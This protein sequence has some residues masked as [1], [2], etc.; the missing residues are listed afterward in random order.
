M[1]FGE[2]KFGYIYIERG[3]RKSQGKAITMNG[4]NIKEL[5]E[6]ESYKYLGQDESIGYKG[7]LNKERVERE[8]YRRVREIWSSE[9]NARNK[10]IAHNSFAIPVLIP[11]IGILD[12][13]IAEIENIDKKTRKIL[14]MMG[15]FHRNSGKD[16]LYLKRIDGGRGLKCFEESYIVRIVG[17]KR[18]IERD[19]NRNHY[20]ENVYDHEKEGIVRIG[21]E[22][23]RLYLEEETDEIEV[24][25]TITD[26]IKRRLSGKKKED[27]LKKPQH[28]YLHKKVKENEN[29]DQTTSNIWIKE[30]KI[31]S[32]VEGFLF[33][34]QEQEIDTRALRKMR[35]KNKDV[36]GP[37]PMNCQLCG[38]TEESI[39]HI[40]SSCSYLSRSLY[41][42]V[43]HNPVAKVVYEELRWEL[44]DS[45]E[46]TY[47]APLQVTKVKETEIW[48]DMP[49]STL[50]KIPHNRPDMI[51]WHSD[52]KD[53]KIVD[54]CVPLDTNVELRHI[55]KIDDYTP[56]VDKL[57][58]IYPAYK[59][60][61]IPV[62]V[63]AL[64]TI[65]KT[66]K[67]SLLKIGLQKVKLPAVIERIQKLA[68]TGT[69][70]IVKYFKNTLEIKCRTF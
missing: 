15:N 51:S 50:N 69:M 38:R 52:T 35:E 70:K 46:T 68:L 29:I 48:W 13:S 24:S 66:L 25:K 8:Y 7:K 65:L 10:A 16:R 54:I 61:V 63:G 57:Q 12:W 60:T 62:I 30:G 2:D 34:I 59:Y 17:L 39:F 67:D 9:L 64:G 47:K 27:W 31:S 14:C 42:H 18:H 55:T 6:G 58:R 44:Y 19:R 45:E 4:I 37:L 1:E 43:R 23:E 3:K 49:I 36:R 40:I 5:E 33:A 11:T 32:H 41:L 56:L 28:G 53:C 20:L 22:Y 26:K 21:Q